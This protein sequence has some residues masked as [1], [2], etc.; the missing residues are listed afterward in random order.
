MLAN[1]NS[2]KTLPC[3]V[4]IEYGLGCRFSGGSIVGP[5]DHKVLHRPVE[6]AALIRHLTSNLYGFL[7]G[8]HVDF[9]RHRAARRARELATQMGQYPKVENFG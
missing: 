6:L 5:T 4:L 1:V 7:T 8:S 9:W 2:N 3:L